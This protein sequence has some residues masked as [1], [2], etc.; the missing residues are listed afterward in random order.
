M[1]KSSEDL[2]HKRDKE[3]WFYRYLENKLSMNFQ[4]K[5]K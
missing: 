2:R 3:T 4:I 5:N 1:W